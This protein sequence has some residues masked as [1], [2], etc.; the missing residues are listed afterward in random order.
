ME[1]PVQQQYAGRCYGRDTVCDGFLPVHVVGI[2]GE[3]FP[4]R[5]R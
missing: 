4:D 3:T 1:S 2:H 5:C